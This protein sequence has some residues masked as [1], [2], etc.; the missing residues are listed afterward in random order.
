LLRQFEAV[1]VV[2]KTINKMGASGELKGLGR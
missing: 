2:Y 1:A